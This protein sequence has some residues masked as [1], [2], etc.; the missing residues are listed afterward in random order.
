MPLSNALSRTVKAFVANFLLRHGQR[1]TRYPILQF[2]RDQGIDCVV[3][4]GANTGQFA[5][6]LRRMGYAG[7]IESFEP[8][9]I[10]YTILAK[11]AANDSLWNVHN[12]ALGSKNEMR[13][14][15]ISTNSPSSSFLPLNQDIVADFVDLSVKDTKSV[16]IRRLDDIFD[17]ICKASS[18]VYM[19][20]DTQG[21]ERDVI[22]GAEET[23]GSLTMIQME[24]SLVENYAGEA[25]VEEMLA[26][27]RRLG[28]DPWWIID[29]FRNPSTLQMYQC[30]FIFAN[31]FR[32]HQ[33][34]A[35]EQDPYGPPD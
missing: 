29:G 8:L 5:L 21:F 16:S 12:Y 27:M 11:T 34:H 1:I 30:D 35:N 4:V 13:D 25:I 3:D 33:H 32:I 31:R 17:D 19:K 18:R 10:E 22:A 24:M 15:L 6:D 28:F 14:I 23:L 9:P 7:R 2:L 26:M 20:I